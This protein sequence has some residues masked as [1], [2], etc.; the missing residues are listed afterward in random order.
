MSA[1]STGPL[2]EPL[3]VANKTEIVAAEELEEV[4][5]ETEE[6]LEEMVT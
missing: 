2:E 5:E 3:A 6:E 1:E 4:S